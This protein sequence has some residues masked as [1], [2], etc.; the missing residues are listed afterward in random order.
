M[1]S[2][3]GSEMC[4]RDSY[5]VTKISG[6]KLADCANPGEAN[7]QLTQASL[8]T[9]LADVASTWDRKIDGNAITPGNLFD[10]CEKFKSHGPAQMFVA[11][12]KIEIYLESVNKPNNADT[13]LITEMQKDIGAEIY[14]VSKQLGVV[15]VLK[16]VDADNLEVIDSRGRT[17][18]MRFAETL[19]VGLISPKP[20]QGKMIGQRRSASSRFYI[21]KFLPAI[22]I[23][24]MVI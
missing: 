6:G 5:W 24:S 11:F 2:L 1:P 15:L 12:S 23:L 3:V 18:T 22:P 7:P 13:K 8:Y 17:V 10:Y 19:I 4:I 14:L 20:F 21:S 16:P 9:I